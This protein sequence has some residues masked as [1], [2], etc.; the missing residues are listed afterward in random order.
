MDVPSEM[1]ERVARA[2]LKRRFYDCEPEMYGT[3]L[4]QFYRDLDP[5]HWFD[6]VA[7]ASAAIEAMMTPTDAMLK[8]GDIPGWDDSVT[9]DLAGE[10]WQAMLSAALH[11][12]SPKEQE[13]T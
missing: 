9:V 5:D 7:E 6:A 2:I 12:P 1:V 11:P 4:D 10:I 3:D 13:R 8:A